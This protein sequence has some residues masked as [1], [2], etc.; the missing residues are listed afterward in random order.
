MLCVSIT[1][2][3]LLLQTASPGTTDKAL[4]L[5]ASFSQSL[6]Q[7]AYIVI[8]ASAAVLLRD[9]TTNPSDRIT[10]HI[11]WFLI[12]GWVLLGA[13]IYHGI[14]VQERYV[15]RWMNPNPQISDLI[16]KFNHH[17]LLQIRF[18]EYGLA[19]LALWLMLFLCRWILRN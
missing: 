4:E 15:A 1:H 10:R 12:P 13:S 2:Y 19:C 8:G 7:W 11:F 3:D 9:L 5:A 14:R 18:M 16:F 17:T 6:S